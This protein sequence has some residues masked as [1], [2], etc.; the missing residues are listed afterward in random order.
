MSRHIFW[1]LGAVIIAA[2]LLLVF[3]HSG[4]EPEAQPA[5]RP[6]PA[7][8]AVTPEQALPEETRTPEAAPVPQGAMVTAPATPPPAS[9]AAP[10]PSPPSPALPQNAPPPQNAS[11]NLET[12]SITDLS[13]HF[14][15]QGMYLRLEG[16]RP[17][18]IRYFVLREPDRLVVDLSGRWQGLRAPAVPSNNLVKS[19]RLGRQNA[20]DRL[21]LDLLAPLQN[22]ELVRL[23]DT[24]FEVYF[25]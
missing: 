19:V 18:Q 3:V 24:L 17:M 22:H 4:D 21:V 23:S 14:R 5:S 20:A 8:I 13:L 1:M 2:A 7:E 10:Q 12:G 15:N 9:Q 16:N 25:Q 11:A 6:R